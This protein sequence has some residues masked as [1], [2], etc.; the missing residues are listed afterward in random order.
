MEIFLRSDDNIG[1]VDPDIWTRILKLAT[2]HFQGALRDFRQKQRDAMGKVWRRSICSSLHRFMQRSGKFIENYK[3]IAEIIQG[4]P[5]HKEDHVDASFD[6]LLSESCFP[7]TEENK[8]TILDFD[9]RQHNEP[10][11]VIS[12]LPDS[13]FDL[14]KPATA[15]TISK[16]PVVCDSLMKEEDFLDGNIFPLY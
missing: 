4:P 16:S 14:M 3:D 5:T 10:A 8:K 13:K 12:V 6:N 9:N 15:K 11:T 7:Q 2:K 1:I